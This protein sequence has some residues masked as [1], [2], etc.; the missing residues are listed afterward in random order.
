MK[1]GEQEIG[2]KEEK[3]EIEWECGREREEGREGEWERG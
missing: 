3:G 2:R 1:E